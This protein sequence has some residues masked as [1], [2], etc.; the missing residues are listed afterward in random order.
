[1]KK[2]A[3]PVLCIA[4]AIGLEGCG[5]LAAVHKKF[6]PTNGESISIDAK[7]RVVYSFA[8]LDS[9]GRT[10]SRVLCAEP[11]PDALSALSAGGGLSAETVKAALS[12]SFTSQ[13]AAASIGLRTQT[14]QVLR[15]AMYRLCEGYASGALDKY[16]FEK[17]QRKYQNN[18]LG[19]LAIEQLTGTVAARQVAL[20]GRA[21]SSVARS[22]FELTKVLDEQKGQRAAAEEVAKDLKKKKDDADKGVAAA[23]GE[24]AAALAAASNNKADAGV[25]K[26]ETEKVKPAK[27]EQLRLAGELGKANA[28][29]DNIKESVA[30]LEKAISD[31]GR[32]SSSALTNA[33]FEPV[34][35]SAMANAQTA[36]V[37]SE[38]VY[39][40]VHD[41]INKD[42]TQEA[43]IDFLIGGSVT[44]YP[45]E[46]LERIGLACQLK[47][48]EQKAALAKQLDRAVT[49]EERQRIQS[50]LLEREATS[51]RLGNVLEGLKG[52]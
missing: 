44:S 5:N 31:T 28:K 1:M 33:V 29:L 49:S 34:P 41:L 12:A 47:D 22:L 19:L 45:P 42:Y 13:E 50:L 37:I 16:Q 15:D 11:S 25:V 18:M 14:I 40:I 3:C 9:D 8:T 38:T 2:L 32:V 20:T 43:C 30:S 51:R 23:E 27:A 52:K 6:D 10:K 7:Q 21:E 48:N 26:I 17:L 36:G 4:A 35:V 46:Q 39:K 24:Y